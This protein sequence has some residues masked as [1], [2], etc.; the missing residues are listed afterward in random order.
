MRAEL[1]EKLKRKIDY[2]MNEALCEMKPDFD[3][4]ITGFNDAWKIVD[5]AFK[6]A[7]SAAPEQEPVA[8]D[9]RYPSVFFSADRQHRISV[10]QFK[11]AATITFGW[12][13]ENKPG[14]AWYEQEYSPE[15]ARQ[16]ALAIL[17]KL[18]GTSPDPEPRAGVG[19][20]A[21]KWGN[22][23]A[24]GGGRKLVAHDCFGN[25]FARLDLKSQG[26]DF[27]TNFMAEKQAAYETAIRSA[28]SEVQ[29]PGG[30]LE[31]GWAYQDKRWDK[32]HW[33]LCIDKPREFDGRQVRQVFIPLPNSDSE[34]QK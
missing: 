4:S 32:D 19:V 3:D 13:L 21:L 23:A 17:S 7:L 1:I 11:D 9:N 18:S 28:L 5:G 22:Y 15:E 8:W 16:L 26:D 12:L 27:I 10:S 29:V 20:K 34:G 31:V 2:R 25:E 14:G 6:D 24:L 30:W 33:H